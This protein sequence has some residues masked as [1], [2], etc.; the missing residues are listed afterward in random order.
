MQSIWF[1]ISLPEAIGWRMTRET[2]ISEACLTDKVQGPGGVKVCRG[3][4]SELAAQ[5]HQGSREIL[6]EL[7]RSAS[8]PLILPRPAVHQVGRR[9]VP[10][11]P[12]NDFRSC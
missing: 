5:T 3:R 9:H 6:A 10:Q 12:H 2:R 4:R 1:Q 8:V 7:A 11:H